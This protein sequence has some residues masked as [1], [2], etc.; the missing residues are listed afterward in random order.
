M[1]S[2]HAQSHHGMAPPVS[3]AYGMHQNQMM[4][5]LGHGQVHASYGHPG[6]PGPSSHSQ[7]QMHGQPQQHSHSQGMMPPPQVNNVNQKLSLL[8]IYERCSLD[9]LI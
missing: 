4:G 8:G 6:F 3:G 2:A 1:H 5:S 9:V 7:P